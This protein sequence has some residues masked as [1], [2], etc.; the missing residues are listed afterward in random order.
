MSETV[1]KIQREI[2]EIQERI[3]RNKGFWRAFRRW[4]DRILLRKAKEKLADAVMA[5]ID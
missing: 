2:R 1:D 4:R 3:K 5:E